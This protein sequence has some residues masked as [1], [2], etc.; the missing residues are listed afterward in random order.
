MSSQFDTHSSQGDGTDSVTDLATSQALAPPLERTQFDSWESFHSYLKE[1]FARTYQDMLRK[2]EAKVTTLQ[3][4]RQGIAERDVAI[5]IAGVGV[6]TTF[7]LNVMKKYHRGIAAVRQVES[8]LGWTL[9]IEFNLHVDTHF[10]VFEDPDMGDKLKQLPLLSPEMDVLDP[11][12]RGS[13]SDE[14]MT[15]VM[16]KLFGP[17]PKV[18]VANPNMISV[19]ING[20]VG[21]TIKHCLLFFSVLLTKSS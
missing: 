14:A 4:K 18:R 11:A 10:Q 20:K 8:A 15:K 6:F 1:Y 3:K 21:Q 7:T 13:L 19:P 2:C 9:T 17:N 16:E 12:G 5:E